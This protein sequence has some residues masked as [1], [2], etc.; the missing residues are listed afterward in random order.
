MQTSQVAARQTTPP[1]RYVVLYDGSCRFCS[2]G[3]EKLA[4]MA[5]PGVVDL[6]NFQEP[7]ALERFPGVPLEACM[8]R[9]H[10]V[11][12]DGRVY[13]GFE[14][15]VQAVATRPL[16]GWI[17]YVY[18]LPGLRQVVDLL[19]ATVAANRYRI[20]GKTRAERECA[21]GTCALHFPCSVKS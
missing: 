18:Y 3:A 9:M 1:G 15:A 13:G 4:R 20:M 11:T 21:G 8:R 10:L 2:A 6:V 19:Y 12:P 5:R 16:L 7:T 17:A 14:A